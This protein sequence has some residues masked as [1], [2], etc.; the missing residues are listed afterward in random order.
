MH[1]QSDFKTFPYFIGQEDITTIEHFK[2]SH[3]GRHTTI[4]NEGGSIY[5]KLL[6][7]GTITNATASNLFEVEMRAL[8]NQSKVMCL[9]D[10]GIIQRVEYILADYKPIAFV[11]PSINNTQLPYQTSYSLPCSVTGYPQPELSWLR[12]DDIY[13]TQTKIETEWPFEV[14]NGPAR[15]TLRLPQ[16]YGLIHHG[17]YACMA[18]NVWESSLQVVYLPLAMQSTT[19]PPGK[20]L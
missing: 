5:H 20:E 14:I 15:L 2:L 1:G 12:I 9:T 8:S 4:C 19:Q 13:N 6:M 17:K 3:E 18:S 16:Y 10:T 11:I 7:D